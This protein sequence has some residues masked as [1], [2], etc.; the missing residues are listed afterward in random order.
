MIKRMLPAIVILALVNALG[1]FF[2]VDYV[3]AV[4]GTAVGTIIGFVVSEIK[5]RQEN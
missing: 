5:V 3:S 4:V 1:Y 2:H